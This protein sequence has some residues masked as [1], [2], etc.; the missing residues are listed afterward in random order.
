MADG[1][2]ID[3]LLRRGFYERGFYERGVYEVCATMTLLV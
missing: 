3:A 2:W 1:F